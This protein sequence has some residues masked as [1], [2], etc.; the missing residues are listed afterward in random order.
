[1]Q[2]A[3]II[4]ALPIE[5]ESVRAHLTTNL[6]EERHQKGNIYERGIFSS[7]GWS[8]EVG[9]VQIRKGNIKAGVQTERAIA[10]FKPKVLFFVGV[11]GGLKDVKLGDVVAAEKICGYESGKA[12][13]SFEPRS[14]IRIPTF[15]MVEQAQAEAR[16]EDWRLRI[17]GSTLTSKPNVFVGPIAAGEKVI[18]SKRSF[19]YKLLKSNYGDALAVEMEGHGFLE[20]AYA[21]QEVDAL[22]IRGISDLIS[23]KS[24]ADKTGWQEIAAKHASAF[25]FEVLAKLMK[26]KYIETAPSVPNDIQ[27]LFDEGFALRD[28]GKYTD[29]RVIF[30][31]SLELSTEYKNSFA[32]AKA[33]YGLA[34]I[35]HEWDHNNVSAKALLKESLKEF[36]TINSEKDV[37]VALFQLGVIEIGDGNLDQAEAYLRHALSIEEKHEIKLGIAHTLHQLGWIEDHRG[38]TKQAIDFYDQALNYFLSLYQEGDPKAEKKATQGIAGCYHHKGLVYKHEGNVEEVESNYVQALEWYRKT[39]FKPDIG[40]ILYLLAE[41]KYQEA[42][43]SAGTEFLDEAIGIY[44]EEIRDNTFYARCLDLKGRLHFTLGHTDEANSM[45]ES[46][47]SAVEK[48][49]N[50]EEQEEYLNKVGH[51]YLKAQKVDKAKDYFERAKNL[52]HQKGLLDG[53]AASVKNLAQ[54]A[55]IENNLDERNKLLSDG[56]QALEKLILSVQADPRKV[57]LTGEIGFL[58]EKMENYQQALIYYQRAKRGYESLLNIWGIANCLG[59]IAHIKGLLGK[60]NEEYDTYREIKKL[61]TGTPYYDLIAGTAINLGEIEMQIGNLNEAKILFQEAEYLCRKYNLHYLSHL[62]KSLERLTEQINLRKPPELNF[63]QLIQEL[64]E[65]VEWF[66]EAKDNILR[67]WMWGRNEALISNYRNSGGVN[68]MVCQDNVDT[69]LKIAEV[70]HPYSDIC[71]QV[72]SS[73]YPGTGIDIIPFPKDKKIFFDCAVPYKEKVGENMYTVNY[74]SGGI[75]SRYTLTSDT[76]RSKITGNEG[77]TIIGWS[78]GLPIQ[79]HQIILSR[80]AEK[81]INNKIFFL[82]YERHLA[83]DKLLTD[84]RLSKEF[85][86]IPVYFDSLPSSENVEILTSKIID[87]PILSPN[88]VKHSDLGKKV[89]KIKQTFYQLLSDNRASAQSSLNT[90]RFEIEELID[91]CVSKKSIPLKIYILDFPGILERE[92]HVAL[93]I[94][95]QTEEEETETLLK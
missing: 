93:I 37:A 36:K 23:K 42:Q 4:T 21:N 53:Y 67:F 62:K 49:G 32:E 35:S 8:L 63:K 84:L 41:L 7:D 55:H 40:K 30:Q 60:K 76:V 88:D 3:V 51:V 77:I 70:I 29:A 86:L 20:A 71:L 48:S 17:I 22:V 11:A 85:K 10:H 34:I 46:A 2:C 26:A 64:F 81:L 59:S 83:N 6:R 89:R 12:K 54:I 61:I 90:L 69:F 33:K 68:L 5:Y 91:N 78:L 72:V 74:L 50:Y 82:P 94:A 57:F 15:Q 25:A 47:L 92:L 75:Y 73:E 45:F 16:K 80:S 19:S 24:K 79:A 27:K 56:I 38:H 14:D 13:L 1:M 58:Y 95:E 28:M 31:K 43:Y 65:L 18:A 87:L 66:P 9:I 44:K 39:G 52:S